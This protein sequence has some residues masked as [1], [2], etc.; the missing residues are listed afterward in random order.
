MVDSSLPPVD[1]LLPHRGPALL[2]DR[3][4]SWSPEEAVCEATL[5]ETFPYARGGAAPAL[6]GI[7]LLAQAAGVQAALARGLHAPEVPLPPPRIG[8]LVSVPDARFQSGELPLGTPLVARVVR[9]WQQGGATAFSGEVHAHGTLLL[10]AE[11]RVF[12]P[13]TAAP[14]PP[15][16]SS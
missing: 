3:V 16:A 11:L 2:L 9:R 1:R 7:E 14:S 4:L 10:T 8:Y 6:C 13:D 12:E 5:S 15:E